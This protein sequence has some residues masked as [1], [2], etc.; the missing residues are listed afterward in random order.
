[1]I[2]CLEL[3]HTLVS[4][5]STALGYHE[6]E[7]RF[8]SDIWSAAFVRGARLLRRESDTKNR[9]QEDRPLPPPVLR[10]TAFAL[11]LKVCEKIS[12]YWSPPAPG[13][14]GGGGG[15]CRMPSRP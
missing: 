9:R 2:C 3:L 4:F 5:R 1:C 7:K 6:A 14:G 12:L 11:C 8:E 15:P 13:A 10:A